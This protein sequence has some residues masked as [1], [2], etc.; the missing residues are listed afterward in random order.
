MCNNSPAISKN[1]VA[2]FLLK[3]CGFFGLVK[4]AVYSLMREFHKTIK[5]STQ[6][7]FCKVWD[8]TSL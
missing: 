8:F 7:F 5:Y 2:N 1:F 6:L 4:N 3:N